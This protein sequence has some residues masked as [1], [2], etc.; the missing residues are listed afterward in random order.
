MAVVQVRVF[1]CTR[2]FGEGLRMTTANNSCRVA[3][4]QQ[5]WL[6]DLSCEGSSA[7]TILVQPRG[8]GTPPFALEYSKVHQHC[9][10]HLLLLL[11]LAFEALPCVS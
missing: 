10:S 2:T 6:G 4:R 8:V 7:G 11:G 9:R 3:V 5:P 1:C